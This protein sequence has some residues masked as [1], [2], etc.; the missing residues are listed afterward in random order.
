M[1]QAYRR[2]Y[3]VEPRLE[4]ARRAVELY[5]VYLDKV[6]RGGRVGDAADSLGE[7]QR[8]V[9]KLTAA[10]AKA[11]TAAAVERTRLGISP[12]LGS[13]RKD[14][15]REIADLPDS[16]EAK[17]VTTLD[18]KSVPPF[19]MVDVAPGPHAIHVEAEGY[20][21]VDTN[22]RAVKGSSSVAEIVLQPKP[23]KVTVTTE[24]GAAIRVDGRPVGTAPLAA[25]DLPAGRHVVAIARAGRETVAREITTT[26]GQQMAI[27]EPLEKT[28]RRKA[29]P[30]VI[31]GAGVLGVASIASGVFAVIEDGRASDQLDAIRA[32]D[33]PPSALSRYE[34]LRDRRDQVR[35]GMYVFGGAALVVGAAAA[36]M[37]GFDAPSEERVRVTPMVTGN[38]AGAVV[39]GRF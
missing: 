4:T 9:D 17:L 23:S 18:G 27:D 32:G 8:E 11:V 13:E 33:Q 5:R 6:K 31:A 24:R 1:A 2:Q 22:E 37:Y 34:H 21:P 29:V 15:V 7:M 16:A 12:Q 35:T 28:T 19:E 10:G 30:W 14:N 3:R 39:T 26:R 38:G 20:I 36:V 25:F